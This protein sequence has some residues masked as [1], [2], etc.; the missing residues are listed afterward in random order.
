[1]ENYNVCAI[2]LGDIDHSDSEEPIVETVC[3]HLFHEECLDEWMERSACC[4]YCRHILNDEF[5]VFTYGIHLNTISRLLNK[6]INLRKTKWCV[7]LTDNKL[8]LQ[9]VNKNINNY[10]PLKTIEIDLK[11]V[12][13]FKSGHDFLILHILKPNGKFYNK[14]IFFSKPA[15]AGLFFD[16]IMNNIRAIVNG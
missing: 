16:H 8:H 13:H 6:R 12:K 14:T 5:E 7:T 9:K 1:M 11:K 15:E 4:P 10:Q 3:D 2:C